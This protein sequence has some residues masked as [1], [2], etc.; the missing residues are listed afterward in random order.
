MAGSVKLRCGV[1]IPTEGRLWAVHVAQ[2]GAADS[3]LSLQV[4]RARVGEGKAAIHGKHGHDS[5]AA[6][7]IE[8]GNAQE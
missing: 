4:R 6:P 8:V 2:A 3:R 1:T 5:D 7:F